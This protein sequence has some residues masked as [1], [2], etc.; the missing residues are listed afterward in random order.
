MNSRLDAVRSRLGGFC[1]LLGLALL[2]ILGLGGCARWDRPALQVQETPPPDLL[3]AKDI[4]PAMRD[5]IERA[6]GRNS[7]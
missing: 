5:R 2:V 6:I 3:G 1:P 4:D 7:D